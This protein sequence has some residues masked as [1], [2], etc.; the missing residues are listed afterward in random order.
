[1]LA[2]YVAHTGEMIYGY[3]WLEKLNGR[4]ESENLGVDERLILG[5]I[6]GK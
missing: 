3:S 4:D 2:G 1:M 5:C 6:L